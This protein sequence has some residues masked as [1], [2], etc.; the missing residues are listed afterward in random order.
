[1]ELTNSGWFQAAFGN[2]LVDLK[3]PKK[4]HSTQGM[5]IF[6]TISNRM[7]KEVHIYYRPITTISDM[8]YVMEEE[9]TV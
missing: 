1:M 2:I 5:D 4:P 3:N 9:E 7:H 8:G 6:T